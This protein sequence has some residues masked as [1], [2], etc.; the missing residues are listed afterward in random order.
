MI[1]TKVDYPLGTVI[2]GKEIQRDGH[3]FVWTECPNCNLK[4]WVEMNFLLV[5]VDKGICQKCSLSSV[6]SRNWRGGKHFDGNG[7]VFIWV[8]KDNFFYPMISSSKKCK[9]GGY[10]MEHR[11]VVAQS[12]GRCINPWEIV[13]HKN[14]IRNDN[15]IAN[16]QLV[17]D[18][19]HKQLTL[20]ENRIRK[21][22]ATTIEQ[23]K[24]IRLLKWQ[25]KELNQLEIKLS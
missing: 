16:L 7:Y 21:L 1:D 25:I 10:V 6:H 22:E 3:L 24:E 2:N 18:D 19:E 5:Q 23:A 8:D 20:M 4:R 15:K 13:H 9:C 12:L 14:R 17:S 11:L